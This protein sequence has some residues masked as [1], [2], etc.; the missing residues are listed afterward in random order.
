M[1]GQDAPTFIELGPGRDRGRGAV[2]RAG[3]G[4][5]CAQ[6]LAAAAEAAADAYDGVVGGAWDRPGL[7][8]NG[9]RFTVASLGR[10]HLHDVV[11]HLRDVSAG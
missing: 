1:L 5:W 8:S 6:E 2:L 11:H 4:R 10:Y 7:R 9:S 3:P